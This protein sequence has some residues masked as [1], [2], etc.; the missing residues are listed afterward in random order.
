MQS[1]DYLDRMMRLLRQAAHEAFRQLGINVPTAV[2]AILSIGLTIAIIATISGPEA[3]DPKTESV[4]GFILWLLKSVAWMG[5]SVAVFLVLWLWNVLKVARRTKVIG[6]KLKMAVKSEA[7]RDDQMKLFLCKS[8][9]DQ[10]YGVAKCYVFG[11]VVRRDKTRDVDIVVQFESSE[12]GPVRTYRNRLRNIENVF[13]D[14]FG[15]KLHLQTF[16]CDEDG[17]LDGFLERAGTY[18]RIV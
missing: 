18:E 7:W 6:E 3:S 9:K 2:M 17:S 5:A 4:A 10:C 12:Q 11:S 1:C 16:L 15:V 14:Y 13:Q 8:L